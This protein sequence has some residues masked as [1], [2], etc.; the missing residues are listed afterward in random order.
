MRVDLLTREYPPHVYG[1]AGVHVA[2][3]SAVLRSRV[4]VRVR[5]FDGPRT[6]ATP[7]GRHR[8]R[9]PADARGRQRRRWRPS[10]STSPWRATSAGADLVHSHTWYA[11]LAGHLAGLLHGVPHVLSAH[12]LE[13]LRPWKAEQLGG[14]YAL[15]GWAERT[16]Y[17]GAAGIIAVSAGMRADILRVYPDV[18]PAKVHV[19]HN[20]IDLDGWV[21]PTGDEA[22]RAPTPSSA[23]SASTR[24]GRRSCSSAASRGRRACPTCCGP[25]TRLPADVQLCSAPARPTRPEIAA[26]VAAAVA[27]LSPRRERR[28]VDRGD[29]PAPRPRR[30]ARR[31]RRSSSAR[32]ST[33]R[34]ASSTSRPW[35][36]A[37]PWSARA[38]GGIPEVVDDGVT[39]LLV[40][41]DQ[42]QDGTG[43]PDWTPSASSPTSPRRSPTCRPT[44]SVPPRW[45]WPP[46]QPRSRTTSRGTRSPTAPSRST[47]PSSSSGCRSVAG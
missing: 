42:V 38:T 34:S 5:C 14:G 19:V 27:E 3:L 43:H 44:P 35:P 30:G 29:A 16:A 28:R 7:G 25:P 9:A 21:R 23:R 2:E 15:S 17:E 41:I 20:G 12:S 13:P 6:G 36:W 18:D 45:A 47:G 39:G 4:D 22:R 8:V 32:R 26:E 24:S 11:N 46:R 33:S 37:C 1:G 40:P 31:V 10:A